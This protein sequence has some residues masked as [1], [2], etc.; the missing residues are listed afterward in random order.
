MSSLVGFVK[1]KGLRYVTALLG[2]ALIATI[3]TG[4]DDRS[5]LWGVFGIS[6]GLVALGLAETIRSIVVRRWFTS[7]L[8]VG[9]VLLG[10]WLMAATFD[11]QTA[12]VHWI[13]PI[14]GGALELAALTSFD[15]PRLRVRV[16][17]VEEPAEAGEQERYAA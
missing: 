7:V 3:T 10:G 14:A 12:S 9:T 15:V 1:E 11:Y 5:A 13:V 4:F 6:I 2:L 16:S 8:G 17:R